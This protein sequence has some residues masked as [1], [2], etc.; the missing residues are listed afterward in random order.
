MNKRESVP[1]HEYKNDFLSIIF[2]PVPEGLQGSF[3]CCLSINIA[4]FAS[5]TRSSFGIC[6]NPAFKGLQLL[7]ADVSAFALGHIPD[8]IRARESSLDVVQE[9]CVRCHAETIANTNEGMPDSDR[10]CFDCHR[11]AAHGERGVSLLPYQHLE[12]S[13]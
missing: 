7:R 2:R 13:R 9:N 5:L 4:R 10:Y 8:A 3:L 12:E 6:S 11:S 1:S